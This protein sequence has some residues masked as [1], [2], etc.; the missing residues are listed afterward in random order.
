MDTCQP[1]RLPAC[2][3]ER[4]RGRR[5]AAPGAAKDLP[6][7]WPVRREILRSAARR[8]CAGRLRSGWQGRD[9]GDRD[10]Y[11]GNSSDSITPGLTSKAGW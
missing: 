11:H 4:S 8:A 2:H 6:A 1:P 10:M 3:P 9:H 5:P 7:A